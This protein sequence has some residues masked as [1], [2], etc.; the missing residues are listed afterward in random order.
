[1]ENKKDIGKAFREKL[2][3]LQKPAPDGGW[4]SISSQ[5]G[6]IKKP[7]KF[8]WLRTTIVS[9]AVIIAIVLAYSLL[10][11]KAESPE[12]DTKETVIAPENGQTK[13][14]VTSGNAAATD[15][16]TTEDSRMVQSP[17]GNSLSGLTSPKTARTDESRQNVVASD[18]HITEYE[19]QRPAAPDSNITTSIKENS[20]A[21]H[22]A[23]AVKAAENEDNAYPDNR[24]G[25]LKPSTDYGADSLVIKKK[26][27]KRDISKIADSLNKLYGREKKQSKRKN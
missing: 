13:S 6:N 10:G 23:N 27:E 3:G 25:K 5:L 15:N 22:E 20:P 7:S 19:T 2:D 1:M 17:S 24:R 21:A 26:P 9:L 12:K 18:K 16:A 14:V 8:P 11:N 4:D